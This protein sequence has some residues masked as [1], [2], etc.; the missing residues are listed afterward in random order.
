M[1]TCEVCGLLFREEEW[2]EYNLHNTVKHLVEYKTPNVKAYGWGYILY[3]NEQIRERD[4]L[5]E[6]KNTK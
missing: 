3:S 4:N 6:R 2:K 1:I 5:I